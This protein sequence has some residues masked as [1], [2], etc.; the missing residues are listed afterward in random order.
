MTFVVTLKQAFGLLSLERRQEANGIIIVMAIA[1]IGEALAVASLLPFL[2]LLGNPEVL[3]GSSRLSAIFDALGLT[4]PTIAL[5]FWGTTCCLIFVASAILRNYADIKV[6]T[7]A[8]MQRHELA[9]GALKRIVSMPYVELL[10]RSSSTIMKTVLGDVD[11]VVHFVLQPSVMLVSQ[12]V[13]FAAIFVL[14]VVLA[15][16]MTLIAAFFVGLFYVAVFAIFRRRARVASKRLTEVDG[17]RHTVLSELVRNIKTLRIA[18]QEGKFVSAFS[19]PSRKLSMQHVSNHTLTRLP[20]MMVETMAIGGSL[21]VAVGFVLFEG[22]VSSATLGDA[23]PSLGLLA[24]ASLRLIPAVQAIFKS[25]WSIQLGASSVEALVRE[26]ERPVNLVQE[27]RQPIPLE[28]K[29]CAE[30][31]GYRYPNAPQWAFRG[32]EFQ[33]EIGQSIAIVGPTG[34]GKSTLLDVVLG[35]LVPSEGQIRIDGEILTPKDIAGWQSAIGYVPQEAELLDGT[36]E[37]NISFD[38]ADEAIDRI[39]F[40]NA[41]SAAQLGDTIARQ[42]AGL[43]TIVGEKG[44]RLS[45][46]ERQRILIAR[47]IYHE[48]SVIVLDEPTS[49]L[50]KDTAQ[51]V[52]QL[53]G[54]LSEVGKTV[55]LVTHY[56]ELAD[57][58]DVVLRFE[59][60]DK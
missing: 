60:P 8:Q 57:D 11:R 5:V 12:L 46:G 21:L 34:A 52:R 58:C 48:A 42:S 29:L 28:H 51:G 40:E 4:E 6:D 50:D 27:K 16:N 45:G 39:R 36:I 30:G 19:E 37:A 53:L 47:A 32:V 43:R 20:R 26:F 7:F 23:L 56:E 9:M 54:A 33:V 24:M 55:F 13:R 44:A 25:G 35:L 38:Y 15:P 41:V 17:E 3:N 49:A 18:G 31:L 2:A 22:G 59:L 14:A 10:D 1:A